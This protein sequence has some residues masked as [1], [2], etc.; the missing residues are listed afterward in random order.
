M[1]KETSAVANV[2]AK[3][4]KK[5]RRGR[6]QEKVQIS[7]RIDKAIMDVAYEHI[8][9]TGRRITDMLERGLLLVMREEAT[10]QTRAVP[11]KMRY[12]FEHLPVELQKHLVK[13][14]GLWIFP[15]VRDLTRLE[16]CFR[17]WHLAGVAEI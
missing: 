11:Q 13:E 15:E 2:K 1:K 10:G 14:S 7:V 9:T 3:P 17:S 16:D 12:L 5:S 8:K 4:K 6:P